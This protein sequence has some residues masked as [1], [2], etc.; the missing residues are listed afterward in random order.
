M[1]A[2]KKVTLPYQLLIALVLGIILGQFLPGAD[3]FYN[4][5][6][7]VFINAI[8]MVILPLIFPTVV[9]AV[10][11]IF[12]QKAFGKI[13]LKTF[14]YFFVVTT[15]LIL[16]Y[17]A[18]GYYFKFGT[19]VQSHTDT[20]ALKGIATRVNLWHF[21]AAIVPANVFSAFAENNLLAVI[22]FAIVLGLGLGAYGPKNAAP[23]LKLFDIWIKAIYK[24]T[25]FVI[26]LSPLGILGIIAHDVNTVGGG[27]LFS[28]VNF[29]GGL[30]IGYLVL[31]LL[32]FPLIA[33]IFKVPYFKTF[34]S[35]QDLFS[36]A[37]F[38][39][40][41]SVVLP[42][43]LERLKKTGTS[44]TVTDFVVP[45]GY[46][47]NLEG[48]V[49]YLAIAVAFIANSYGVQLSL[50]SVL[51]VTLL[52]T[53]ISKTIATVP[54]GAVVVLLATASQLGL[55]KEGVALIFAVDFFANAG[56]TALNVLG[57]ALAAKVLD[58][59]PAT[60]KAPQPLAAKVVK[61]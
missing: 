20:Q 52:L 3:P 2:I 55:P 48:A 26:K 51:T 58:S 19:G 28:L 27:K 6:G 44:A 36:L 56:R 15:A 59:R 18:A 38:S 57:N 45:L 37:F 5:L 4:L 32:I 42:K 21:I 12:N 33:L 14:V 8:T 31:A 41:S 54:S 35:I 10:V 53:L 40:S 22:F 43:L 50:T 34:R 13:L 25:D 23:L 1:Q 29:I 49:V 7:T 46:T 60:V 17:L 39:G 47:F 11:Q 24:I 16:L 61:N 30:Y 9:V